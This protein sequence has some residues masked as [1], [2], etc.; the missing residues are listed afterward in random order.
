MPDKLVKLR[1]K[2]LRKAGWVPFGIGATKP[3][4]F[5]EMLSIAWDNRGSLGYAWRV[6]NDG[7][8]DGCA[9]GTSGLSDHTIDGTHLCLVRL[10]LLRLNTM[11][12]FDYRILEDVEKLKGM[13][14]RELR[15]LGRLA[16]PM[17]RRAGEAGFTRVSWEE[18]LEGAGARLAQTDP[19]RAAC[20]LTSRGITN[21]VYYAAQKAWRRLGSPH[22]DNAARLCHS[23]S[24][25]GMKK[26]MGVAASTC[27]YRDWY[28]ADV[29]VFFGSNPAND[30]PVA[31]K[32][33]YE[34]KKRGAKVFVVNT[35]DE[36][37]MK[38]Y[39]IPSN[40]D[41]AVLGT[42]IA[43]RF[44]RVTSGGDMAFVQAVQQILIGRR[45]V[46]K[47]FIRERTEGWEQYAGALRRANQSEL[48]ARA[49]ASL[50]DVIA[51]ADAIQD[52][53]SGVFVWSMGITQHSHGSES[54]AEICN[55]GLSQGFVGRPGCGLMPI[56]GHSGV[57][58]GA[59]MGAYATAYPGG[60]AI[61][62]EN[63]AKL[64]ELWGFTPPSEVGLDTASMIDAS[65]RGEIDFFYAVGG[66][67]RDTMPQPGAVTKAFSRVPVRVHQDIF[68]TPPMLDDP[69]EEVYLLPARTRYEHRGGVTETTTERRVFF[70]PYVPGHDIGEA[71]EEWQIATD[72]VASA[73]VARGEDASNISFDNAAQ[74]RDD[75]SR[76]IPVYEPIKELTQKGDQFQWGGMRLCEGGIFPRPGGR[77]RF[78]YAEAPDRRLPAGFFHLATRRGKQFN[79][80][81]QNSRDHLTGAD[82]DH[83]FMN[84]DEMRSHGYKPGQSVEVSSLH[85]SLIGRLFPAPI[86]ENCLQMHWPE[87][88]VLIGSE[89]RDSGGLVPDY[90]AV[91]SLKAHP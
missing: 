40:F 1:K 26:T 24:T 83:I 62:A 25:A 35:Y 65:A 68:L 82:R 32:Y 38:R 73:L 21:E 44:F 30:Q 31:L 48:L 84:E 7:V 20:Y 39:W 85:G 74:I 57:Q 91:V 80:L 8:C 18:A 77:A 69:G 49:G 17:R 54:V 41:S 88:N 47:E 89:R 12:A 42:E 28:D 29:I 86:V 16:Y 10:N 19:A 75:I 63:A 37:G 4:H 76:T 3:H 23:P 46:D 67:F 61:N 79:S 64:H 90:N 66:N 33:L 14:T 2:K 13:T 45:A 81:V 22:V 27:S 43:D 51:F 6:L 58:G 15:E 9:L 60:A 34:A 36:P 50:D 56:R 5:L 78:D 11:P 59:E 52:A 71:R 70:S 72:L 53:Q 87:A 55:L